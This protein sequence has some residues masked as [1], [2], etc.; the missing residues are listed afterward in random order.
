MIVNYHPLHVFTR[1]QKARAITLHRC[2]ATVVDDFLQNVA[3]YALV[4]KGPESFP[5]KPEAALCINNNRTVSWNVFDYARGPY[6]L[7]AQ[8][9]NLGRSFTIHIISPH[10]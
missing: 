5:G 4:I 6:Q 1:V 9:F 7:T 3:V 8:K 10:L 2:F